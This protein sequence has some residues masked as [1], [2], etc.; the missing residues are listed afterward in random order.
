MNYIQ[1]QT[2]KWLRIAFVNLLIVALLGTL[3]RYK[4]A[5]SLPFIEQQKIMNAHS[6]FSFVG[7]VTQALMVLMVCYLSTQT[8]ENIFK[9]YRWIFIAN[10]VTAYG[11]LFSFSWEGYGLTSIIFSTL[12]IFVS[13]AFAFIFW[14]DLN[15]I[16]IKSIAHYWF[17]AALI[18][19]V[20]SSFGPFFLAY[21]MANHWEHPNLFL[22]TLYYFLHFQYNG[23]FFFACAGLFSSYLNLGQI[24]LRIQKAIFWL[25]AA[26]CVPAYFLSALWL[27]MSSLAYLLVVLSAIA[28]SVGGFLLIYSI[29]KKREFFLNQIRRD[30][31][32][33]LILSA[34]ALSIKL[35]L[36]LASTI[37]F[38]SNFAFGFRPIVIGYLH[39]V[40]LGVI[41][42]FI[43]GYSRLKELLIVNKISNAGVFLFI[44]GIILNE[45]FL[46]FQGVSYMN[47]INIANINVWLLAAA[48]LMFIG[49][50][51]LNTGQWK[52]KKVKV[53]DDQNK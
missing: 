53:N 49:I 26:A 51:L 18:F 25:F 46:M 8:N 52:N 22:A 6:H 48:L 10:L 45:F 50:I 11:M 34:L 35:F 44:I 19:S 3:M 14:K 39:L 17:I 43:I 38:L 4:I 16:K 5:Y 40:L 7:W 12:S 41:T 36:Q 9:K 1:T 32:W 21:M 33:I 30:S 24:S 47:Y 15:K 27:P 13:Y 20:I 28:Q 37:P 23:W 2:R 29:I 42:L 31:R